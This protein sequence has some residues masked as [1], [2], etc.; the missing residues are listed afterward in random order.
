MS[1]SERIWKYESGTNL[2]CGETGMNGVSSM[3]HRFSDHD[4]QRPTPT[5]RDRGVNPEAVG[6][7]QN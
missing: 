1:P 3:L 2:V 5:H 4:L 7:P 6:F